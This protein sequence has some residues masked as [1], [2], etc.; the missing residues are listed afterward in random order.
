MLPVTIKP[1]FPLSALDGTG[2]SGTWT[3]YVEDHYTGD[4]GVL[5][6]VGLKIDYTYRPVK[7][8]KNFRGNFPSCPARSM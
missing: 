7:K 2:A 1:L 5:H 6:G 8:S 3:L 4:R